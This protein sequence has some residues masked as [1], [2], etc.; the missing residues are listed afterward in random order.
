MA[1]TRRAF[2][3][4]VA[5][6]MGL[7]VAA[8]VAAPVVP[9]VEWSAPSELT[10]SGLSSRYWGQTFFV[11]NNGPAPIHFAHTGQTLRAGQTLLYRN[12]A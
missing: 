3:A 1:V 9:T 2:L 10:L 6:T 5:G 11:K 12:P 8:R 4:G 7:C